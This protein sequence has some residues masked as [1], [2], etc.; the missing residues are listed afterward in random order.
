MT[1]ALVLKLGLNNEKVSS[2]VDRLFDKLAR[3]FPPVLICCEKLALQEKLFD[4]VKV[5][6]AEAVSNLVLALF[7]ES[8]LRENDRLGS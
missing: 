3:T 8:V 7:D 2:D 6:S 5:V 1:D 4:V